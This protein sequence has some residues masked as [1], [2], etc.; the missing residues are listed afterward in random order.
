VITAVDCFLIFSSIE[1]GLVDTS[2]CYMAVLNQCMLGTQ[3]NPVVVLD[4]TMEMFL[5][6]EIVSHDG[7]IWFS[8]IV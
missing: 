2:F 3:S 5:G 4:F 6:V 8:N 7:L 1:W